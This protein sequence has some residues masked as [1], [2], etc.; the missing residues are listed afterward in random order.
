MERKADHNLPL[1]GARILVAEDE[2]LIALDMEAAFRDAG[3]DIV[4]P[5]MTLEAA[6]DAARNEPLSL[7]VLD[8]RLGNATTENVSDLLAERG[9][10][11]LFYSGQALPDAMQRKCD[12]AVVVDKPATQQDLVGAA[13]SMLTA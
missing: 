3:A 12:G 4:G 13:A 2:L 9:I 8:I 11:F 7:A 10:P 5:C 1:A 6:L